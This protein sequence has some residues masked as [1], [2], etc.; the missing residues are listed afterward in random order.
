[1]FTLIP[2][3]GTI[4]LLFTFSFSLFQIV[5]SLIF[6][7]KRNIIFIYY[8][9]KII[10]SQSIFLFACIGILLYLILTND[11]SVI[12]IAHSSQVELPIVYKITSLWGGGSGSF[13]LWEFILSL[14]ISVFYCTCNS[15]RKATLVKVS[16][17]LAVLSAATILYILLYA[18]PFLQSINLDNLNSEGLNP[19]LQDYGITIHP[20][21]LYI[22]YIGFSVVFALA[23]VSVIEGDLNDQLLCIM[24]KY[25]LYAW[26][27]LTLG[28][29]LGGWWAYRV[30]GWGGWWS[31]D[32]VENISLLPW[33]VGLALIHTLMVV[34]TNNSYKLWGV[35]L[36][37]LTFPLS[38]LGTFLTRS[39]I[40]LSSHGF[41]QGDILGAIY[42]LLFSVILI[43]LP[44]AILF[45]QAPKF[46]G[47]RNSQSSKKELIM[48]LGTVVIFSFMLTVLLGTIYPIFIHILK[49]E[50][51]SIGPAYFNLMVLPFGCVILILCA[52]ATWISYRSS[53]EHKN[54]IMILIKVII[55]FLLSAIIAYLKSDIYNLILIMKLTVIIFL[56]I[57]T[58]ISLIKKALLFKGQKLSLLTNLGGL[59]SHIGV[60]VMSFAIIINS[61][62]SF[63][64]EVNMN[65]GDSSD[66]K[67]YSVL[68]ENLY[69]ATG[70]N[71]SAIKGVFKISGTSAAILYPEI[72]LFAKQDYLVSIPDKNSTL[73]SDI[74][75]S[76]DNIIK[77]GR[78]VV[79][80]YYEPF[81]N[82][83][84]LGGFIIFLGGILSSIRK[85]K[86]YK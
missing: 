38:V 60:I 27:C 18:N 68:F 84:W 54:C 82:F 39:G 28:I 3:L 70:P 75:I 69:K 67:G 64:K 43:C 34:N 78:Q 55:S 10:I 15:I 9:K 41:A 30:L 46:Y 61:S 74:Y 50:D 24:R 59:I 7:Y 81:I 37:L 22:G 53:H 21:I 36:A 20:P 40:L 79:T 8:T 52:I 44:I 71:Y 1:M 25:T 73:S 16:L 85:I 77:D 63:Q 42:L 35:F 33:L 57:I 12:Y 4:A 65:L 31:W 47:S 66:I 80:L 6:L 13:L 48:I 23:I 76:L 86:T 51:I 56:L 17:V 83:I 29:I 19:L 49:L 32:P 11:F 5:F 58:A 2:Q 26:S 14:W 72:R 45:I 62:F